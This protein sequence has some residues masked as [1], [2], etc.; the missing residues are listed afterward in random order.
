MWWVDD[1][2]GQIFPKGGP[3]MNFSGGS[4][5]TN[6]PKRWIQE[7]C[8]NEILYYFQGWI[9]KMKFWVVFRGGSR[10]YVEWN[11]EL[12][13]EVDPE[14][15]NFDKSDFCLPEVNLS[16][17]LL[18]QF[19]SHAICPDFTHVFDQIQNS[20]ILGNWRV[21]PGLT[22]GSKLVSGWKCN[23]GIGWVKHGLIGVSMHLVESAWIKNLRTRMQ[24]LAGNAT[25]A[26]LGNTIL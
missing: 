11:F 8:G 2:G 25:V 13:S 12:F 6:N 19:L 5:E 21:P 3:E 10:K 4:R 24:C 20:Q 23:C 16:I 7:T 1:P 26:G 17:P 15:I 22:C 18:D 14:N 9:Q